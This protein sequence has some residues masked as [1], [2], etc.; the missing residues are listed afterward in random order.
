MNWVTFFS[1]TGSEIVNISNELGRWPDKVITNNLPGSDHIHEALDVIYLPDRPS[2]GD[3][4]K[5][6]NPGD[7]V[8]L[9]GW[10]RIVPQE[11]CKQMDIY[12]LHPGLI[13]KYPELKGADPQKKVFNSNKDYKEVGCVLHEVIPEVDEGK[14]LMSTQV[15]NNFYS[16]KLLSKK[17]HDIAKDMWVQFL[18]TKLHEY[19]R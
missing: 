13:T 6:I 8:T 12:N 10:M 17:L 9:H 14:V 19:N 7:I 3:Y 15:Y 4:V 5:H 18:K 1:H 11:L 2:L 16:E